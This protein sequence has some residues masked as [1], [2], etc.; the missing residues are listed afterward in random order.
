MIFKYKLLM[1][2]DI[3]SGVADRY[4]AYVI[5]EFVPELE[6]MGL[7]MFRVWEVRYGEY[8]VRQLEFVSENLETVQEIFKSERW[9]T[10]EDQF[11]ALTL[12]Y[13]RKLVNFRVGFQF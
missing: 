12:N 10:L 1:M 5:R 7:Y 4:F 9:E 11:K 3:R 13:R 6:S 2:Y 8:P